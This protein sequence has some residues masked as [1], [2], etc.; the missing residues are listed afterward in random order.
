[1][2][3][4]W[5]SWGWGGD[6]PGRWGTHFRSTP[7]SVSLQ[8]MLL[9]HLLGAGQRGQRVG[10][11]KGPRPQRHRA[12]SGTDPRA[13]TLGPAAVPSPEDR[14]ASRGQ[15]HWLQTED[16]QLGE[17]LLCPTGA[18]AGGHGSQGARSVA[19]CG[20][21]GAAEPGAGRARGAAWGRQAGPHPAGACPEGPET[22]PEGLREGSR[23]GRDEGTGGGG[24]APAGL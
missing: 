7:H 10:R 18:A 19:G 24:G 5:C 9:E 8:H 6:R 3:L 22:A 16:S 13:P 14:A 17:G 20:E 11:W 23:Q 4:S 1:M 21:G 12:S 15:C 2:F